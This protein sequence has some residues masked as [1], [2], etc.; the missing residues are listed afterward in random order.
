MIVNQK[1]IHGRSAEYLVRTAEEKDA[2]RLSNIRLQID[3]E[4]EY[5][6]RERG[7]AYIDEAGF[8]HI[9]K[10]DAESTNNLFLAAE[11]DGEIVGF[12]RCVGST[13]KR[14]CHQVEFGVCV[15]QAYWGYAIG[16]NLL[17][18]S[19]HWAKLNEIK[20]ITLGVIETNDKAIKLYIKYG[21][22]IEGILKKDKRLADG[23]YYHTLLMGKFIDEE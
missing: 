3:G 15:L 6:D 1:K 7:E 5:M 23:N 10:N 17:K 18:E 22:E 2:K 8:K 14:T 21:F 19:I 4:T 9:I 20:K 16:Q 11:I 13:L 12:S